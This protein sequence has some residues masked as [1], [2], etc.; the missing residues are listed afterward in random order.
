MIC[1][2][3][4][5]NCDE[6]QCIKYYCGRSKGASNTYCSFHNELDK[7]DK[8]S[9]FAGLGERL[10][11]KSPDDTNFN[12]LFNNATAMYSSIELLIKNKQ[13]NI[14]EA[15]QVLKAAILILESKEGH[16]KQDISDL[17]H[18]ISELEL[19]KQTNDIFSQRTSQE[20]Q[21]EIEQ[22][23]NEIKMNENELAQAKIDK[24]NIHIKMDECI[25]TQQQ[26][27]EK[28]HFLFNFAVQ[29]T[30]RT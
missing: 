28:A 7:V 14:N 2:A 20:R 21:V 24:E 22:Y 17:K 19:D 29:Q 16:I 18:T 15:I 23:Q 13:S 1:N 3:E 12:T 10:E 4:T 26:L 25:K 11:R 5:F 6:K 27:A 9:P 30:N 8:V